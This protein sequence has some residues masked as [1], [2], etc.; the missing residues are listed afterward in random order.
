[1]LYLYVG[2]GGAVG[3]L[4]RYAL[5]F[6]HLPSVHFFPF[7]TLLVNLIGSFFLGWFSVKILPKESII[8]EVKAAITSG[9]IGSFTTFSTLTMESIQL[10]ENGHNLALVIYLIFSVIGGL[11]LAALGLNLAHR[12]TEARV[13]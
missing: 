5:S 11:S 4:L 12:Q 10:I 9:L 2:V 7:G 6:L 1:M 3:S 13:T 8:R